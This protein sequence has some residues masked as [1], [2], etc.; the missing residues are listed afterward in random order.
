MDSDYWY[1]IFDKPFISSFNQT[2]G[3]NPLII[4]VRKNYP[5]LPDF[6]DNL[7]LKVEG[8]FQSLSALKKGSI[9]F[10]KI[11]L[12]K[13]KHRISLSKNVKIMENHILTRSEKTFETDFL[14]AF[15]HVTIGKIDRGKVKGIHF[16]NPKN[17]KIKEVI[18]YNKFTNVYSAKISMYNVNKK[19]W[20]E[21]DEISHFFPDDWTLSFLFNELDFAFHNKVKISENTYVG[22]TSENI[23]VKFII[24]DGK[25]L[26]I[27]PQI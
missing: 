5:V 13:I 1:Y 24:K 9:I 11:K 22:I 23:K 2:E 21:K 14:N 26:T 15:N 25:I 18:D 12:E 17:V 27:Y 16:F 10:S 4:K 7:T 3:K 8:P 6:R 19:I 20:V